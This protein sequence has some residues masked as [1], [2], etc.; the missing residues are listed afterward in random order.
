LYK[1]VSMKLTIDI[2]AKTIEIHNDI[3]LGSLIGILQS[4]S[5]EQ[6]WTEYTILPFA[7]KENN[8][9]YIVDEI[10]YHISST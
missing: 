3:K 2:E 8:I 4:I 6:D 7:A 1:F 10:D 5:E 9:A